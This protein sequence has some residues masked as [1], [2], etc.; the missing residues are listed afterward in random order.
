MPLIHGPTFKPSVDHVLLILAMSSAGATTMP[1]ERAKRIGSLIFERA[2]KLG[3]SYA[4]ERGL[5]ENPQ[6]TPWNIKGAT[7]S[8]SIAL[9]S[10]DPSHR[11]AAAAYHGAVIS[12]S[13]E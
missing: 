11:A 5:S 1:G 7:I 12:V 6:Y 13:S 2:A 9:L 8:Q 4:W 3:L 10:E